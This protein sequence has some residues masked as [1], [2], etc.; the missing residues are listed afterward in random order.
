MLEVLGPCPKSSAHADCAGAY[1]TAEQARL[2]LLGVPSVYGLTGF[3]HAAV[4][5]SPSQGQMDVV[6]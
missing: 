5:S 2:W 3:E 6:S 4:L 1:G